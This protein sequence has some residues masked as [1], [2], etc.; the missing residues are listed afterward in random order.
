MTDQTNKLEPCPFCGGEAES[1]QYDG[2]HHD[3]PAWQTIETAPMPKI[4]HTGYG[5]RILLAVDCGP[6]TLPSVRIGWWS[7][8]EWTSDTGFVSLPSLGYRVT[9]WMPLPPAPQEGK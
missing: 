1:R 6:G 3:S 8:H 5:E 2:G 7:G 4:G 9:H